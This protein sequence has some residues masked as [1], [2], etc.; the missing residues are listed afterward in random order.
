MLVGVRERRGSRRRA[1]GGRDGRR[2]DSVGVVP[3]AVG[4]GSG[5][6]VVKACGGDIL[7]LWR[8]VEDGIGSGEEV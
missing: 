8:L 4:V 7:V 6:G 5:E 1:G 3:R 2:G